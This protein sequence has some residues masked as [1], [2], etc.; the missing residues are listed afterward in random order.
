MSD[1]DQ[2]LLSR[3]EASEIRSLKAVDH[4]TARTAVLLPRLRGDEFLEA[5][6]V[7]HE[8]EH[9]ISHDREMSMTMRSGN[10][11][12]SGNE[13]ATVNDFPREAAD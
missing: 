7:A 6:I 4:R 1:I 13:T 10:D 3:T 12:Q 5:R 9:E 11:A 2:S 8:H